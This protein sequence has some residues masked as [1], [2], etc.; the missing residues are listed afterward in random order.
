MWT[1]AI[2][3][4]YGRSVAMLLDIAAT[5]KYFPNVAHSCSRE[6]RLLQWSSAGSKITSA[7]HLIRVVIW[8]GTK[9]YRA[10]IWALV[11]QRTD[12]STIAVC[13]A[14]TSMNDRLPAS[15]IFFHIRVVE[16]FHWSDSIR[17]CTMILPTRRYIF[18]L[19][20]KLKSEQP[21]SQLDKSYYLIFKMLVLEKQTLSFC[22]ILIS[23][24]RRHQIPSQIQQYFLPRNQLRPYYYINSP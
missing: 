10:S 12:L 6:D 18:C 1:A 15:P 8:D 9:R 14:T 20:M 22:I 4:W 21:V 17:L 5:N 16:L 2:V 23:L 11:R 13:I 3:F 24:A 19:T 7:S